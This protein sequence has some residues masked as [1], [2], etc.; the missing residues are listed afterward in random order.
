MRLTDSQLTFISSHII[1]PGKTVAVTFKADMEG[2]FPYYCTEFCSA[3]HLEMMG[4]LL[5]KD[6]NKKYTSA[7][8]L[9]MA[10][11]SKEE[12]EKEYKKTVAT[13][14]ATDKVIQSVVKFLKEN[15]YE[16]YPVVKKLVEDAHRPVSEKFPWNQKDKKAGLRVY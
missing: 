8:K 6:P 4:Y 16:K 5:V 11:M 7:R 1:E 2:V 15:H 13:N 9:K 14:D 10:S 3:L 12:L